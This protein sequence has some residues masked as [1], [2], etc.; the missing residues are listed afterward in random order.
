MYPQVLTAYSCLRGFT[1]LLLFIVLMA[2]LRNQLFG[3]QVAH[4][5]RV[6]RFGP[7]EMLA[8]LAQAG[9]L[10]LSGGGIGCALIVW[11]CGG[12]MAI[13]IG[14]AIVICHYWADRGGIFAG[15]LVLLI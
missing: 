9:Q 2:Q 13:S 5:L 3:V 10:L 4:R 12:T 8:E 15:V 14:S 7:A 1:A 11:R 6:F